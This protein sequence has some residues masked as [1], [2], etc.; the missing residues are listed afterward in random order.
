MYKSKLFKI[1]K[2]FSDTEWRD[3]RKFLIY[4]NHRNSKTLHLYDYIKR[5]SHDLTSKKLH[6]DEART[7]VKLGLMSRKSLQNVM[8]TLTIIIEEY[9]VLQSVL[10]DKIETDYKIFENYNNRNLYG[11]ANNKADSLKKQWNNSKELDLRKVDYLLKIQHSQFFSENPIKYQKGNMALRDLCKSFNDFN[12]IYQEFYNYAIDKDN[13]IKRNNPIE[14][15]STG[16]SDKYLIEEISKILININELNRTKNNDSFQYLYDKLKSNNE[17]SSDLK[18]LIFGICESYLTNLIVKGQSTYNANTILHLYQLGISNGILLYNNALATI[19]F[20]N[21]L[22]V[23][24]YLEEFDWAEDYVESYINLVPYTERAESLI[25]AKVQIHFGK[26][27]Y[28][29]A[30]NYLNTSDLNNFQH[31]IQSRWYSLVIYFITFDNL[32]FLDSQMSSFTQFFY[33]NKK[34]MS[35]RNFDGS[36]NLVKIFKSAVSYRKEFDLETEIGKYENITFKNRLES[37]FEQRR[38]YKENN[39]I[40]L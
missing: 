19:R 39:G 33:Y 36:L 8:S 12:F 29:D 27:E 21:I 23:A 22:S 26:W 3:F 28:E 24:C 31:K 5:N 32:D 14:L 11:L 9:L 34:R 37:I 15:K 10:A 35:H 18:A 2:S 40:D 16:L 7:S 17:I 13:S 30:L 25:L 38:I 4:K 20:S 6:I 1:L